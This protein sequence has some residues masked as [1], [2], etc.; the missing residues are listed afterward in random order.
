MSAPSNLKYLKSHEWINVEGSS[1]TIGLT[2]FA[3]KAI[4][5]I[6]FL[7][8]PKVGDSFDAEKPLGVIESVKAVFDINMPLA[9]KI[10][11]INQPLVD[12][13]DDLAGDPFGKGWLVKIELTD[14]SADQSQLLDSAAY[15]K[16]CAEEAH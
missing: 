8:L 11:Q 1:A 14:A 10:T 5:D 3:V 4:Q 6:V 16:H 15:D 12:N 7:E 13:F 2:D 9:G